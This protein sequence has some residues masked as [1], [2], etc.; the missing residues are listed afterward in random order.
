MPF[1]EKVR[2]L[3]RLRERDRAIHASA[4]KQKKAADGKT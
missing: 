2:I 1:A 3:E 4:A